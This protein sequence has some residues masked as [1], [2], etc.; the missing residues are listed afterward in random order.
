MLVRQSGRHL[1]GRAE[2]L[3]G[4]GAGAVL[5]ARLLAR[6]ALV[7]DLLDRLVARVDV[8]GHARRRPVGGYRLVDDDET[9]ARLEAE[10][11][12]A[13]GHEY[14]RLR[15]QLTQGSA[16]LL[17]NVVVIVLNTVVVWRGMWIWRLIQ[18]LE[19]V[20]D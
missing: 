1:L 9:R 19:L 2:R 14:R 20:Q 3:L 12:A 15:W 16:M 4:H 11:E 7:L 10:V 17:L 18:Q 8:K 5:R 13:H 6:L